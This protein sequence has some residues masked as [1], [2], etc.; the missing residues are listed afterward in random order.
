MGNPGSKQSVSAE[1]GY[2][3][4]FAIVIMGAVVISPDALLI[5]LIAADDGTLLFWRGVLTGLGLAIFL[6]LRYRGAVVVHVR[7]IGALGIGVAVLMGGMGVL[8]I[9]SIRLTTAANT[10]L[11]LSTTPLF[12]AIL[13]RAFLGESLPRST[14]YAA[15]AVIVG[16]A[17]IFGGSLGGDT[18]LGDLLGLAS[19]VLLSVSFVILRRARDVDMIPA[20]ALGNLLMAVGVA[21]AGVPI[22]VSGRDF[23]LLVAQGFVMQPVVFVLLVLGLRRIPA[24]DVSLIML[25]EVVLGPLWVWTAIGEVPAVETFFGGGVVLGTLILY[26]T[27]V[28]R[29]TA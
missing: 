1:S 2:W 28:G 15:V 9:L 29:R 17:V 13:S 14:W 26:S 16:I 25:L 27:L 4:G 21:A 6:V 10:L 19:A 18:L 11:M 24:P 7:A 8:F 5:R 3:R 20:I 23:A 22:G 12:A